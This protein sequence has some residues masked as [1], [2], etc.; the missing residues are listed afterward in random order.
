MTIQ[1]SPSMFSFTH[2]AIV[3]PEIHQ[4][5]INRDPDF[6]CDL[7]LRLKDGI[8]NLSSDCW[9]DQ[10]AN[11]LLDTLDMLAYLKEPVAFSFL[12]KLFSFDEEEL[13]EKLGEDFV[14]EDLPYL[15]AATAKGRWEELRKLTDNINCSDTLRFAAFE[16]M[17]WMVIDDQLERNKLIQYIKILFQK[18][19]EIDS[20]DSNDELINSALWICVDLWPGECL[21]EI[22]ELYGWELFD[23]LER[24]DFVLE[25]FND[26]L[27]SCLDALKSQWK[28]HRYILTPEEDRVLAVSYKNNFA[29]M[30]KS[31]DEMDREISRVERSILLSGPIAPESLGRNDLC[32]CGCGK[33]VKKCCNRELK[34]AATYMVT[35]EPIMDEHEPSFPDD[36]THSLQKL[37]YGCREQPGEYMETLRRFIIKYPDIPVLRNYLYCAYRTLG[38]YRLAN[39]VL[40]ETL[41]R[42][43]NYLFGLIEVGMISLRRGESEKALEVLGG[44]KTLKELYP[45]RN[46]FH[47]SEVIAFGYF[48]AC[49]YLEVKEPSQAVMHL[50]LIENVGGKETGQAKEIRKR[51]RQFAVKQVLDKRKISK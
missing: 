30:K 22:K 23:G 17:K 16:A 25:A 13:E 12:L 32:N 5:L 20:F 11:S 35:S 6:I 42:F 50:N 49:Y 18:T 38:K 31:D 28:N 41:E 45:T 27:D 9:D 34:K 43:P 10:Q 8:D 47:I 36:E 24:I 48:M 2:A 33:K 15:L 40:F 44:R 29:N 3:S 4:R 21:E 26:G 51:I 7:L 1:N 39:Q 37:Y 14:T 46:I 19:R